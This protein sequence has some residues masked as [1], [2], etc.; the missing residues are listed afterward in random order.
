MMDVDRGSET[1]ASSGV[2]VEPRPSGKQARARGERGQA[3]IEFAFLLPF[4]LTIVFGVITFG[5]TLNNYVILISATNSAAQYLSTLRSVTTNPCL[6]AATAF[7]QVAPSLTASNLTFTIKL[8]NTESSAGPPPTYTM[9]TAASSVQGGSSSPSCPG[10][11]NYLNQPGYPAQVTVS[12]ECSLKTFGLNIPC[13][14][15][16]S[17]TYA[18][19]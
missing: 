6:D 16:S 19:E 15:T 7:Y 5:I 17:A 2:R 8:S 3:L 1:A 12:Y 10:D 14:L 11:Q 18:V 9:F 13:N 4:L